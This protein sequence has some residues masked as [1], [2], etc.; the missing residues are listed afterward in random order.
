MCAKKSH[1]RLPS[2]SIYNQCMFSLSTIA[3]N[4]NKE[5]DAS[6]M[7]EELV[8]KVCR[9]FA[10]NDKERRLEEIISRIAMN[11]VYEWTDDIP[12]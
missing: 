6:E 7:V 11:M 2:N 8:L 12:F 10:P 9:E 5:F 3:S 4:A 1:S